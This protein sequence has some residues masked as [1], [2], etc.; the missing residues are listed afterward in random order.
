MYQSVGYG[1]LVPST[2]LGKFFT[3]LYGFT[4]IALLGALVASIGSKLFHLE[5]DAINNVKKQSQQQVVRFYEKMPHVLERYKQHQKQK[6]E[7]KNQ[8]REGQLKGN[9]SNQ[10]TNDQLLSDEKEIE[11]KAGQS[12]N[13]FQQAQYRIVWN[14]L[15]SVASPLAVIL[16]SGMI[17]GKIEQ[18]NV[19]DSFYYALVTGT[20]I[21]LGDFSPQTRMGK[22]VAIVVIP[23]LVGATG[24]ILAGIGVALLRRRQRKIFDEQANGSFTIEDI[25]K[26]DENHN[27]QVSKYEYTL[28]MLLQMDLVTKDEVD[29]LYE[30]FSRLDVT[31]SGYIDAEDLKVMAKLRQEQEQQKL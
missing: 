11:A 7:R 14:A 26:M 30:Q 21:G 3:C 18:W 16:S 25:E 27:G 24:E 9:K 28:Y 13:P 8:K 4:G 22:M 10:Q 17:M 1:D 6:K 19:L 29:D 31:K 20:T 15:K 23:V 2:Y 12:R 5:L